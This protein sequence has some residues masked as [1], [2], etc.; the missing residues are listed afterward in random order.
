[1]GNMLGSPDATYGVSHPGVIQEAYRASRQFLF[2]NMLITCPKVRSPKGG[3]ARGF[4]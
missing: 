2:L 3:R 4:R 1:M